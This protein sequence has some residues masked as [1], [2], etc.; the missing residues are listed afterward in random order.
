MSSPSRIV[1]LDVARGLA[2]IGMIIVHMAS[3]LW[4]TKVIIN[5]VPSALFAVIAGT[6]LMVIGRNYT[7]DTLLRLVV[8][9]SVIMLLGLALLPVG[10]QIQVVL[11]AMGLTMIIVSWVPP[12][13][14]WWKL[15]LFVVATAAATVRY[16]PYTLPQ[17]YPLLAWIAYFIGGMLLY[18]VYLK[19]FV[20]GSKRRASLPWAVTGVSLVVVAIGM[21]F[22]FQM[23]VPGWLRFTGH[24]GVLGE[25]LLS[26]AASAV[27]F[28][29]CLIV[30][31]KA[32][33]VVYP[34]A[35]MGSMSLTV[36][37]LHVLTAYWW[38]QNIALH[39]TLSALGFIVFFLVIAALW[40]HFLGKGPMERLVAR[41]ITIAVPAG[42]K[43]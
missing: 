30:G 22:R 12:L 15:A 21:Y 41:I 19:S 26:V 9:G 8:R 16:A 27:I 4:S 29:L 23:D 37:M 18:E 20:T 24:T 39:S 25:I 10:G 42:K 6:T 7:F 17:I 31:V 35:A 28:H 11:V 38:Q 2:I 36:Y 3:L 5:G 14:V 13:N 32:P 1:G 43:A 40:K 34:V 33:K